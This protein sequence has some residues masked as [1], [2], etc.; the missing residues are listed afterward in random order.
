MKSILELTPAAFQAFAAALPS[1]EKGATSD[2]AFAVMSGKSSGLA[3][4]LWVSRPCGSTFKDL[5]DAVDSTGGNLSGGDKKLLSALWS[6]MN[7]ILPAKIRGGSFRISVNGK[8]GRVSMALNAD[9][10]PAEVESEEV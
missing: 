10:A 4:T 8:T 3:H 2:F 9:V 7:G 1:L 5:C 6:D